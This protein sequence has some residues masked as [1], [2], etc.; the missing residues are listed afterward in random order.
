MEETALSGGTDT[1]SGWL[2][3]VGALFR[4]A[5]RKTKMACGLA[6]ALCEQRTG[7]HSVPNGAQRSPRR[8]R[9]DPVRSHSLRSKA[10]SSTSAARKSRSE[11]SRRS[12][13]FCVARVKTLYGSVDASRIEFTNRMYRYTSRMSTR[14][15]LPASR[16]SSAVACL[17]NSVP[18]LAMTRRAR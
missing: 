13:A 12:R 14:L 16:W 2:N 3:D 4:S 18:A 5:C 15:A 17:P 10:R 6:I 9:C 11:T 1:V 8:R 7:S